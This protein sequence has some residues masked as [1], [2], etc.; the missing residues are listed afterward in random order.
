[1]Y[2]KLLNIEELEETS[3]EAIDNARNLLCRVIKNIKDVIH[4]NNVTSV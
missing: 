2:Q 1:M 4:A 3:L